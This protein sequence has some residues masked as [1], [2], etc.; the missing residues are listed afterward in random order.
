[1]GDYKA[2]L[3]ETWPLGLAEKHHPP[4]NHGELPEGQ[5]DHD[6]QHV[7]HLLDFHSPRRPEFIVFWG[8]M[9]VCFLIGFLPQQ[10]SEPKDASAEQKSPDSPE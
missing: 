9:L 6:P 3:R 8:A 4:G 1:V 2:W 5:L 7:P 10:A